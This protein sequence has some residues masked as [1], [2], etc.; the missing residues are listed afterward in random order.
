MT[1]AANTSPAPVRAAAD[2]LVADNKPGALNPITCP[3]KD[4]NGADN[5]A[6]SAKIAD[7][8]LLKMDWCV[9]GAQS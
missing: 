2:K 1:R 8:D 5:L 9:E 3:I 6:A 7:G 4:Q